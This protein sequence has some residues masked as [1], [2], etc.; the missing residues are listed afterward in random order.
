MKIIYNKNPCLSS[1]VLDDVE[2]ELFVEKFKVDHITFSL[3][4]LKYILEKKEDNET[5]L[6]ELNRIMQYYYDEKLDKEAKSYL[7][8]FENG[9]HVG[10]CTCVPCTCSKCYA[11]NILGISTIEGLGKHHLYKI[12]NYFMKNKEASIDDAITYLTN[13]YDSGPVPDNWKNN[14]ESYWKCMVRWKEEAKQ[15]AEWLDT[16]HRKNLE[17]NDRCKTVTIKDAPEYLFVN[18]GVEITNGYVQY[19]TIEGNV[20]SSNMEEV[21]ALYKK[22]Y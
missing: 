18:K 10:D 7:S 13:Y 20:T 4:R 14:E 8:E 1:I 15:A 22:V 11:E 16:V 17:N 5:V 9:V 21:M 19:V 6:K 12:D 2:K 3:H